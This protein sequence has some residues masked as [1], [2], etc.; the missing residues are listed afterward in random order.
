MKTKPKVSQLGA[1]NLKRMNY[2]LLG[3]L[4]IFMVIS[5]RSFM[6]HLFPKSEKS[7]KSIANS[8]YQT[9][10]I[11]SAYRGNIYDRKGDPLA[12]SIKKPSIYINP[13]V[14]NPT[15]SQM[16]YLSKI[17]KKPRKFLKRISNKNNYFSW[18]KRKVSENSLRK[19]D[20]LNI[21]G[22]HSIYEPSRF[23][24]SSLASHLIGYVGTDNLGLMGLESMYQKELSGETI[25]VTKSRDGKG[26]PIFFNSTFAVPEKPGNNIYL[27]L[28][29]AI[30]EITEKALL[31]GIKNAEAKK[32]FAIVSDPFTGKILAV[33]NMPRFNPHHLKRD[34][35]PTNNNAFNDLYE[36]GSVI[37][38]LVSAIALDKKSI[39]MDNVFHCENGTYTEKNLLIRDDHPN[40]F[41][42]AHNILVKSSNIGIYK[43]AHKIGKKD[44]Y[45]GLRSFGIG[46]KKFDLGLSGQQR[47]R[48]THWEKWRKVRFA[49]IAFGQG[50]MI[51]GLELIASYGAIANGGYLMKPYILESIKDS[52]DQVLK[53]YFPK[54]LRRVIKK[55]T[56]YQISLALKDVVEV[57]TARRAALP[58]Y[59]SGG[60]TGTSQKADPK[61]RGYSDTL[62]IASFI[63]I[64]PIKEPHLVIYVV[65]DEPGKTPA[66]GGLW[67]APVFA[68]IAEKSLKYLNV[69]PDKNLVALKSK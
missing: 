61:K 5:I 11:L 32:G 31:K 68:E 53:S 34:L 46:S 67:A 40:G 9:E 3:T 26:S 12:I 35:T 49:N 33:A 24:P 15:K 43:I 8:Q 59:S 39:A 62:R 4:I 2:V 56:A 7:L 29:R 57:G 28:D 6:I 10:F 19:L 41:L 38:P 52:D 58:S 27:T 16:T 65:I 69:S 23:Y 25:K 20:N 60:K 14:F 17:L 13:K 48:I 44:L 63:G 37:K 36:P 22:L 42:T 30:Q 51:T 47:G 1:F 55:E 21:R 18:V 54:N 66:Y 64:A 45:L 50:L